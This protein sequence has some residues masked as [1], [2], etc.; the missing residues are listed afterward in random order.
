MVS[1]TRVDDETVT[2]E[3]VN[4]GNATSNY[5]FTIAFFDA[6]GSRLADT[7][8]YVTALRPDERAIE[9]VFVFDEPGETCEVIEAERIPIDENDPGFAD[10]SDCTITGADSF[11]DVAATVSATNP[12]SSTVDYS[13]DVA[14][15]NADGLRIGTGFTYIEAVRPE[16]TAPSD[17]FTTVDYADNLTCDVVSVIRHSS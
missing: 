13:V 4:N 9:E 8:G 5:F 3:L 12:S 7:G 1:C 15:V 6:G 2:I 14:I 11:D 10:I 16:E 17:V